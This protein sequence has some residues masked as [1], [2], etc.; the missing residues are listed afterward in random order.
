[1][2]RSHRLQNRVGIVAVVYPEQPAADET[3]DFGVMN[4]DSEAAI[5]RPPARPATPH[6]LCGRSSYG[7][8]GRR[9]AVNNN[10][11]HCVMLLVTMHRCNIFY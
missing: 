4:F 3:V 10:L 2:R 6:S 1:M 5:T 11:G 9:H 7:A 8:A